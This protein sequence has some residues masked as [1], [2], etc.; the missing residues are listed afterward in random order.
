MIA[1][2][3]CGLE[4][5]VH[6][7]RS[8]PGSVRR[9]RRCVSV[10]CKGRLTTVELVVSETRDSTNMA[11]VP[12]EFIATLGLIAERIARCSTA[13]PEPPCASPDGSD[14]SGDS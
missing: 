12:V 10:T 6:E 4:T 8:R 7:T 3:V 14:T 1:C 5:Q 2:P 9:R 13:K 11:A